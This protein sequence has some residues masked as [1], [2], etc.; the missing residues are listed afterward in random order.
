MPGT[1]TRRGF[2]IGS[3][4]STGYLGMVALATGLR[5]RQSQSLSWMPSL[6]RL[7]ALMHLHTKLLYCHFSCPQHHFS[8]PEDDG[9]F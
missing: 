3:S 7:S 5:G 6:P 8:T 1:E 4:Y 9:E 2:R